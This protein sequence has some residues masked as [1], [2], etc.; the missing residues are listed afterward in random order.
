MLPDKLPDR[1]RICPSCLPA[2]LREPVITHTSARTAEKILHCIFLVISVPGRCGHGIRHFPELLRP[3]RNLGK[4]GGHILQRDIRGITLVMP[5]YVVIKPLAGQQ[6]GVRHHCCQNKKNNLSHG[7]YFCFRKEK[8]YYPCSQNGKRLSG[9]NGLAGHYSG[10][11]MNFTKRFLPHKSL[12]IPTPE[13]PAASKIR[14]VSWPR[15]SLIST[16]P[17][18]PGTRVCPAQKA[19]AL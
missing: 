4:D 11:L 2:A 6:H 12:M 8:D 13:K 16:N 9:R 18:P 10:H 14:S 17:A 19:M 5:V 15:A 7:K 1:H 3:E